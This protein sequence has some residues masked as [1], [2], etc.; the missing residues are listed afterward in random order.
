MQHAQGQMSVPLG[1]LGTSVRLLDPMQ[2][3]RG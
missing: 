1:S 2:A 3:V